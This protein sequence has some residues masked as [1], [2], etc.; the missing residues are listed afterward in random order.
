LDFDGFHYTGWFTILDLARYDIIIGKR[1]MERVDHHV[2][3][4]RNVLWIDRSNGRSWKHRLHGLAKEDG[5]SENPELPAEMYA[6]C[7]AYKVAL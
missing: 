1:W 6:A 4:H 5:R 2:N 3:L 7:K